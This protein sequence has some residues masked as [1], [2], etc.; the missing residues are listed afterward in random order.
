MTRLILLQPK[1]GLAALGFLFRRPLDLVV[2]DEPRLVHVLNWKA[3]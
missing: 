3:F 2:Y 1:V